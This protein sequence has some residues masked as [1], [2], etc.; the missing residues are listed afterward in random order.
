MIILLYRNIVAGD[1]AKVTRLGA[2]IETGNATI[3]AKDARI[4]RLEA[5]KAEL[6]TEVRLHSKNLAYLDL[7]ISP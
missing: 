4:A 1:K 5:R 6:K 7:P 2:L 3:V